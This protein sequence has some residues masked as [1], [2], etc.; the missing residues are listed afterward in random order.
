MRQRIATPVDSAHKNQATLLSLSFPNL[1]VSSAWVSKSRGNRYE[2]R[3]ASGIIPVSIMEYEAGR[4]EISFDLRL[5]GIS[6]CASGFET[7]YKDWSDHSFT[8]EN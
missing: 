1:D 5:S 7:I 2:I 4:K 6:E 8:W 3:W